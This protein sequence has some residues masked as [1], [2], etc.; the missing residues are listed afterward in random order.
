MRNGFTFKDRH[1][2]EF[3]VTVRTKSRPITAGAKSF[4]ADL[5]YRDGEYDFSKA[6]PQGREHYAKRIF[7]MLL[8]L[9]ADNLAALQ[10]KIS[11]LA[12][13]LTGSGKLIF[14]DLPLVVWNG[15]VTDEIV[16]MPEHG[17]TKAEVEVSI[18]VEPLA[19]GVF[20]TEG[21]LLGHPL[22]IGSDIP[23]STDCAYT[24]T[25]NSSGNIC[26]VNFGDM[27]VS[28][29]IKITGNTGNIT[30][31]LGE[32]TLSFSAGG[33]SVTVDFAKQTVRTDGGIIG[34]TGEFFELGAGL[35]YIAV[36][37]SAAGNIIITVE[38]KPKHMY[39]ADYSHIDWGDALA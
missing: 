18:S 13:W 34:V 16:Y 35:N 20:G 31:S 28:P 2:S 7:V 10:G 14:D 39:G 27:P 26:V 37:N 6:N 11:K 29:V 30:L 36:T 8:S 23:L 25:V 32:K 9:R 21:P 3:G 22:P 38:F 1:S 15:T 19:E 5:P 17:G 12:L 33:E 4:T 24:Y